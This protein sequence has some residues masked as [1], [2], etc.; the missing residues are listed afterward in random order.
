MTQQIV[1]ADLILEL[2]V[3]A[4]E[5]DEGREDREQVGGRDAR[6]ARQAVGGN[7]LGTE[8][9]VDIQVGQEKAAEREK[10]HHAQVIEMVRQAQKSFAP[11]VGVNHHQGGKTGQAGD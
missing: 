7:V 4:S 3:E 1:R 5:D 10:N 11:H 6:K 9:L 2:R 8:F